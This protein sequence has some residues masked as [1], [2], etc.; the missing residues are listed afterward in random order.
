MK[1]LFF[2]FLTLIFLIPHGSL[3][4]T[5]H[6]VYGNSSRPLL[7]LSDQ[8]QTLN[9]FGPDGRILAQVVEG[10]TQYLISDT[11]GSTR[12]VVSEMEKSDSS[13]PPSIIATFDYTPYGE[14]NSSSALKESLTPYRY[15]GQPLNTQLNSYHFPSREYDPTLSRFVSVDSSRYNASVYVYTNNNP[16]NFVDLTGSYPVVLWLTAMGI[17]DVSVDFQLSRRL[18]ISEYNSIAGRELAFPAILESSGHTRMS[19]PGPIETLVISSHGTS[20]DVDYLGKAADPSEFAR[21]LADRL[22]LFSR[23]GFM[24]LF[25][26]PASSHVKNIIFLS[27]EAGKCSRIPIDQ[28]NANPVSFADDFMEEAL[29][30]RFPS[31]ERVLA[32][33]YSLSLSLIG[34][35]MKPEGQIY[36][37]F[38]TDKRSIYSLRTTDDGTPL[39]S[40]NFLIQRNISLTGLLEGRLAGG[41]TEVM[42]RDSF[43]DRFYENSA[44]RSVT[45]VISINSEPGA[46]ILRSFE[47]QNQF[48]RVI[49]PPEIVDAP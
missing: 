6:A 31:L 43:T 49:T 7:E 25:R 14:T 23:G 5:T 34:T 27:C 24:G 38:H 28:M 48:L 12:V 36:F 45:D 16:I 11:Q 33:P 13:D 1:N 44:I 35:P 20:Q 2:L 10:Q 32:S 4:Q 9:I 47:S 18:Y 22:D 46:S 39:L 41:R 3:A 30:S 17:D 37:T 8:G 19:L 29:A 40:E 42:Y 21:Y 15:T 26:R